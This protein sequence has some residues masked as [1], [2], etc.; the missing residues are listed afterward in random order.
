M[1]AALNCL[2]SLVVGDSPVYIPFP[3]PKS[4]CSLLGSYSALHRAGPRCRSSRLSIGKAAAALALEG[5][6]EGGTGWSCHSSEGNLDH[7]LNNVKVKRRDIF[8][9]SGRHGLQ[10]LR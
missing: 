1:A 4:F 9:S 8:S 2:L 6:K 7:S 5:G 3:E 10:R